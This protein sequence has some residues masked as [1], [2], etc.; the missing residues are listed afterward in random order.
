MNEKLFCPHCGNLIKEETKF[1]PHCG[2][3]VNEQDI[4]VQR[5]AQ[6]PVS[7]PIQPPQVVIVQQQQQPVIAV[8]RESNGCADAALI[9]A[10][11]GCC[12]LPFL[13][14]FIAMILGFIGAFNP[15]KRGTAIFSLIV[16][17]LASGL[18][19][20]PLMFLLI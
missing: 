4:K 14:G 11:L 5:P 3:F 17:F 15:Y 20:I 2:A 9:F 10:I 7:Q 18:W 13:G 16:G 1:C 19:I 12:C 6:L 8:V